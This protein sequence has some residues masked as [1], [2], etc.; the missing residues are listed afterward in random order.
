MLLEGQSAMRLP[1]QLSADGVRYGDAEN[2]FWV[3][4]DRAS[5]SRAK[6]V[7]MECQPPSRV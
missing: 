2:E 4:G 1:Q 5:L 6:G 7:V 3:K